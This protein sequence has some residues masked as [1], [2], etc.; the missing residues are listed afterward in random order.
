LLDHPIHPVPSFDAPARKPSPFRSHHDHPFLDLKRAAHAEEDAVGRRVTKDD[1]DGFDCDR[2]MNG[3]ESLMDMESYWNDPLFALVMKPSV[4]QDDPHTHQ[5]PVKA[6]GDRLQCLHHSIRDGILALAPS[7]QGPLLS[8]VASWAKN[9]AQSPLD[10]QRPPTTTM[11]DGGA[12]PK[13]ATSASA[14]V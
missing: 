8:L 6:L 5:T 3:G 11:S 2:F 4:E 14:S 13:N 1:E 9:V 10:I 7:E 12:S